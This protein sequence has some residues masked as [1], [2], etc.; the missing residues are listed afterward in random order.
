M[1]KLLNLLRGRRNRMERD[2][3]R[4]L[5]FHVDRRSQELVARGLSNDDAHRQARI[6]LGG[7]AQVQEQV[8]D[9]WLWRWLAD[10]GRDAAYAARALV[11]YPGF[12][13]TAV[14]SLGVGI[15]ASAAIFSLVDQIILR[16]LPVREPDQLAL[17]N[18][19]GNSLASGYGSGNLTSYPLC[20]DLQEQD[21][22]F[23]GVFCRHPTTV[24]LSADQQAEPV[25][26]ELVSGSYFSVLGVQPALGRLFDRSDDLNIGAHPVAVVSYDYWMSRLHGAPD[27]VGRTV[28]VNNFPMTVIGVTA[29]TF[30]GLDVGEVPAIWIPVMM[31]RQAL[32]QWTD[33][34]D[35]R[36]RWMH[37]FGRLKSGVTAEAAQTALQPWF[38]QML[39][40]DME[41]EGFPV[42]SE[43]QRTE[44]LASTIGIVP[45]PNG[46]S[47]LRNTLDQ[48]LLVLL[49]GTLLLHLL[50]SL[51]VA[52]LFLARGAGRGREI[53]TRMALG[54]SRGRIVG[55]VLADSALV[56]ASG[57]LLGLVL[58]PAVS[59][60]LLGFLPQE[61]AGVDIAAGVD[62][63]VFGFA[64]GASF[65][66]SLLC[67]LALAWQSG[68]VPLMSSL[69]ERAGNTPGGGVRLRKV[70]V[71]GQL[72]FTLIL[73]V[74]AGL[75][76]QTLAR[77]QSAG[78][79]FATSNLLTFRIHPPGSGYTDA[80]SRRI[81][82]TV[83]EALR[84]V[85]EVE[86]AS[87]AGVDLLA[88]GSWSSGL[89]MEAATRIT[90]D[91]S[92]HLNSVSPGFFST[93]GTRIVDGRDFTDRDALP[94]DES[95]RRSVVINESLAKRYFGNASPLGRHLGLGTS[96]GQATDVEIIGVVKD[97]SY[98]N[99]REQSEQ[100]FFP[101]FEDNPQ[102]GTF[103][104]RVRG[105]PNA[106]FASVR[107][108]VKQVDPTLPLLAMRGFDDQIDRALM[109]ER[110]LATLSSGF[111]MVALLLAVVGLYGVMSFVVTNRTR[112]I[113][114]RLALGATRS[115]AVW[116]V[117]R[118]AVVM[119]AAGGA[120][121][122]P[123]VWG[124]GR[125]VESQLFG[126]RA[127][128]PIT[129]GLASALLAFVVLAGTMI[130]AW[131]AAS[132][133]PTEALRSE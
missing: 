5:Q 10:R 111:A 8:R 24:H 110:M 62:M 121:A 102:A 113:G 13:I 6:E 92:V 20:R 30:H 81:V 63:R 18:W 15:G 76:V 131:R 87:L 58:A 86:S 60:L 40:S 79:G 7:R 65:V 82:R 98:R 114:I 128:D 14:V 68:R 133:R 122:L 80:E 108:A 97:F 75:F 43:R 129:I 9:T 46:R 37:T 28:R 16:A 39:R 116:H 31:H 42:V 101:L 56:A 124:L 1:R 99:L 34:I 51:N 72:A 74:G 104:L 26:A 130:P 77:L 57:A 96:P 117:V 127:V 64:V 85:P 89:T 27:V 120:L 17:V 36:V 12:T 105:T 69:K 112:E 93:L 83:L 11:R 59:S 41:L 44:F 33:M 126:V 95:G 55:L 47:N 45:A 38:K 107:T 125:L 118:D 100:A 48:P 54:A 106:T 22:I 19:N 109:T 78:P 70:L 53:R 52:S 49:A 71:T 115:S 23:E 90:T 3:T 123:S 84:Q 61:A 119:V 32:P 29:P 21:Q 50:A 4:E 103:Y 35:R 67:G 91:R 88:G 66:T 132:I 73:L 25:G 2:L 94:V